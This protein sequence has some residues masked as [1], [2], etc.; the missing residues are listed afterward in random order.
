MIILYSIFLVSI[1]FTSTI[2][3]Q[4]A[5]SIEEIISTLFV[6]KKGPKD[7]ST[8]RIDRCQNSKID[9]SQF[10]VPNKQTELEYNFKDGCDLEGVLTPHFYKPFVLDL[11]IRNLFQF[12]NIK[13]V[14]QISAILERDPIIKLDMK[15]GS[16]QGG[17]TLIK[18]EAS[19]SVRI[20]SS[21]N[22]TNIEHLGGE[23]II[24]KINSKDVLIKKKIKRNI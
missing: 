12:T 16:L 14:N 17:Q 7:L 4:S 18:F 22:K 9:W 2:E 15:E 13:S 19:Y 21:E 23:I 24:K 5:R 3:D 20:K 6:D 8:F 11:K 10:L 1:A